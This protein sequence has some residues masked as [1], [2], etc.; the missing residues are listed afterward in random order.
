MFHSLLS[1]IKWELK[2][3]AQRRSLC[4]LVFVYPALIILSFLSMYNAGIVTRLPIAVIDQD[5]STTSR[6][7]IQQVAAS[8]QL[9]VAQRYQDLT[10]AKQALLHGEIYAVLFIQPDFEKNILANRQPEVITF[11]NNQYMTAGST[12]YRAM[13]NALKTANS[14]IILKTL[15]QKGVATPVAKSQMQTVPTALHPLFN[16]TL[17]YIYTLINGLI[18]T[19]LQII[20]MVTMVNSITR[21]RFGLTGFEQPFKLAN[22]SIVIFLLGRLTPYFIYF[23]L[24]LVCFDAILISRYDLPING[25]L[26]LLLLG[27]MLYIVTSLLYGTFLGL[28]SRTTN[29]A[30]GSTGLLSS[31][32]FGFTGLIF[33][34]IAMNTFPYIWSAIL[35]LTWYIQIRL[36]QTLRGTSVLSS[37]EPFLYLFI[38]F[39]I[40]LTFVSLNMRSIS[41]R[42]S[43]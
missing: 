11:Y 43:S 1:V 22:C 13:S 8:P 31:P 15:V 3:V 4:I 21:D 33:P 16:P 20:M 25:H 6:S 35:P 27:S 17:N 37:L 5:V 42:L 28:V 32:A 2:Q 12:I 38:Q 30:Y 41:R 9:L 23:L 34:R 19:I 18:P 39:S 14:Q 36:D 10:H 24:C 7:L 40:M 29:R 26:G